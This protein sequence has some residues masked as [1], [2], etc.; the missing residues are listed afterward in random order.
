M[1]R[2]AIAEI[3]KLSEEMNIHHHEIMHDNKETDFLNMNDV[4]VVQKN[5]L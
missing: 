3:M 2:V 4:S 1:A 5:V